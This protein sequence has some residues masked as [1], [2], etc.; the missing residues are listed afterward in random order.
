M[1]FKF[2]VL[3]VAALLASAP[4]Y[5][6]GKTK[7][8]SKPSSEQ[9]VVKQAC[10]IAGE[11]GLDSKQ[12]QKFIDAY[13]RC[14]QEV[15]KLGAPPKW[16]NTT[17][18][19]A[20]AAKIIKARLDNSEKLIAIRKKYYNEYSKFLTQRQIW[21]VYQLENKVMKRFRSHSGRK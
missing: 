10:Y 1:K 3:I 20:E 12:T 18:D 19:D 16:G 5:A 6:K 21:Q 2:L 8:S 7:D 17:P 15:K 14:Q 9:L 13:T 11:L 4:V